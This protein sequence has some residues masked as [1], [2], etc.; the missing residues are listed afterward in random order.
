MTMAQALLHY[1][2]VLVPKMGELI[3]SPDTSLVSGI[4]HFL[5]NPEKRVPFH[6]SW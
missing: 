2:V 4:C 6:N 1:K 5:A 3:S